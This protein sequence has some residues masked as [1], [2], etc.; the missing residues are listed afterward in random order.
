VRAQGK[1]GADE[2]MGGKYDSRKFKFAERVDYSGLR[3]FV[4]YIDQPFAEKPVP[5]STPLEV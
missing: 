5:P 1:A 3:D 2:G 4:V